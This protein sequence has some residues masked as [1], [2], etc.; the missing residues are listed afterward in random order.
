MLAL[1]KFIPKCFCSKIILKC[2]LVSLVLS[3]LV[4]LN[5]FSQ[6]L[7]DK[8]INQLE[9]IPLAQQVGITLYAYYR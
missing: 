6:T 2:P 4:T 7:I 5:Q 3:R 9:F 1:I 8:Y